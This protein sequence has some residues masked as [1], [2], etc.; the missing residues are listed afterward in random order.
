MAWVVFLAQLFQKLYFFVNPVKFVKMLRVPEQN[1][2]KSAVSKGLSYIK[3]YSL[4]V[5]LSTSQGATFPCRL[6]KC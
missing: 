6:N 3:I 2:K 4:T 5:I 1:T